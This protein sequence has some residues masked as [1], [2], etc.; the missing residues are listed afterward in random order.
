M[1]DRYRARLDLQ[2]FREKLS[3][4]AVHLQTALFQKTD[5]LFR[6]QNLSFVRKLKTA[7]RGSLP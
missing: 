5:F 1:S 3:E 2:H 6:L 7:D 4:V